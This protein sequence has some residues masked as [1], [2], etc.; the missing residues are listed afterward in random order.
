MLYLLHHQPDYFIKKI[1]SEIL[2]GYSELIFLIVFT[3]SRNPGPV[4]PDPV[5]QNA[6]LPG[7]EPLP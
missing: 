6:D 3:A 5:L 1:S 2:S 7:A 4:R